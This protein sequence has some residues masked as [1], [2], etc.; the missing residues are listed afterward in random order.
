[1]ELVWFITVSKSLR[2]TL[3]LTPSPL[4][5]HWQL[6]AKL[7]LIR[8]PTKCLINRQHCTQLQVYTRSQMNLTILYAC[9]IIRRTAAA[10]LLA[11]DRGG[12]FTTARARTRFAGFQNTDITIYG[13]QWSESAHQLLINALNYKY[14]G[15]SDVADADVANRKAIRAVT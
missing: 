3:S 2:C 10:L 6:K 12:D 11:A 9:S 8:F 7:T 1:M 4:L 15:P 13:D 5:T 14:P